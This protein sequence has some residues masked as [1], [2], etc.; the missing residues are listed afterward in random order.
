MPFSYEKY[1]SKFHDTLERITARTSWKEDLGQGLTTLLNG[2]IF[3]ADRSFSEIETIRLRHQLEQVEEKLFRAYQSLGKK[4]M[5]HWNHHQELDEKEKNRIFQQIAVILK[6]K[7]K[8]M[9]QLTAEKNPPAPLV[10][11]PPQSVPE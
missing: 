9:D 8:L 10:P 11:S 5:D 6:E 1:T 3:F 4:C 7:E 2:G